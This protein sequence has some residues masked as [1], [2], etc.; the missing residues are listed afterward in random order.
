[1]RT[2]IIYYYTGT[3]NTRYAASTIQAAMEKKGI[4]TTLF[5]IRK[6]LSSIPDPND[7]DIAGF[8]YPVHAFNPPQLFYRTVKQ[9]PTL[10]STKL[11]FIF[12][13]AGEPFFLNHASSWSIRRFL[14]RKGFSLLMDIHLLMPYNILFRYDDRL[15]KQMLLHTQKMARLI[16]D[17]VDKNKKTR[18]IIYPWTWLVMMILRLIQWNGAKIN[19]PLFRVK[20]DQCIQCKTCERMCPSA[21]ITFKDGYPKFSSDCSM[22]MG[23]VMYCPKDAIRPGLIS[24]IRVNGPY[25]FQKLLEDEA[26]SS[27]YINRDTKGYFRGFLDYYEKTESCL[28]TLEEENA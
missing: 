11:A 20:K 13:T 4:Q 12:K 25:S 3:G 10:L 5:D 6:P 23:C 9:L 15:A 21:N 14:K 1:M 19:G 8:G 7:F 26:V 18:Q 2:A 28:E 16:A 17:D 24:P 27:N 22:C